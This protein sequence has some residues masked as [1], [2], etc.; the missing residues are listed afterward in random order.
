M[1][2]GFRSS[3][4]DYPCCGHERGDCPDSEGCMT[5][6]E[7]GKRLPRNAKSSI[8]PQCL[9]RLSG[10]DNDRDYQEGRRY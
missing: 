7:C 10:L 5:C 8:C 3:C 9:R 2:H 1:A 6:V 4:E